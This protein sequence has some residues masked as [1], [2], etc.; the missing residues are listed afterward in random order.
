VKKAGEIGFSAFH[1]LERGAETIKELFTFKSTAS[2]VG[3]A[4]V[5]VS[6]VAGALAIAYVLYTHKQESS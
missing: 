2:K 1:G 6:L 3:A 4:V 5:G